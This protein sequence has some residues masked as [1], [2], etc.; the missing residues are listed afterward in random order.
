MSF[1]VAI[2][3]YCYLVC[4]S[5]IISTI[6]LSAIIYKPTIPPYNI[7]LNRTIASYQLSTID[8]NIPPIIKIGTSLSTILTINTIYLSTVYFLYTWMKQRSTHFREQLKPIIHYYNIICILLASIVVVGLV[9]YKLLYPTHLK[10]VCNDGTRTDKSATP[11]AYIFWIF[12]AQ[13]FFEFLDTIFFILRKRLCQVSFLHLYH[14][15]SITFVVGLILPYNYSGDMYLPI[16]LNS[17]VHILMYSH[18]LAAAHGIKSW[19]KPY[20]TSIQLIQF[21][22]IAYQSISAWSYGPSCG[23]PDFTKI[24]MIVYMGSMFVLFSGFFVR[25]YICS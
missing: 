11:I 22:I 8:P 20:L 23:S 9:G 24:I 4:F 12:Y 3:L 10:F 5:T 21:C 17:I 1:T 2:Q 16:L 14:H 25:K 18:Y 13:K 7:I 6:Y 15:T 19:W